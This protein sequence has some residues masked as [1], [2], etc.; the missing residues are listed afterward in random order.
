MTVRGNYNFNSIVNST[1]TAN[2][3]VEI[4]KESVPYVKAQSSEYHHLLPAA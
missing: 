4:D 3:H 2:P 1:K